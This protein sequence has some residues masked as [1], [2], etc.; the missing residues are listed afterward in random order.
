M[1]GPEFPARLNR[2][3]ITFPPRSGRLCAAWRVYQFGGDERTMKPRESIQATPQ[4]H[5]SWLTLLFC[6]APLAALAAIFV[7]GIPVSTVFLWVIVLLCPLSHLLMGRHGH[8][9]KRSMK[10]TAAQD[11]PS[12]QE[13]SSCH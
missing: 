10:T 5:R 4:S 2:L 12:V 13:R 6:V 7:F 3:L 11:N 8:G 1:S 9:P